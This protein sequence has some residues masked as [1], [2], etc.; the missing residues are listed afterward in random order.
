M[1]QLI[2]DPLHPS[3][4]EV[5]VVD[6]QELEEALAADAAQAPV[7]NVGLAKVEL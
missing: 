1:M 2:A 3:V 5:S 7:I 6:P 4:T